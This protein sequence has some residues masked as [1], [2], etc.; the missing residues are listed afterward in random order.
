VQVLSEEKLGIDTPWRL[1]RVGIVS[2]SSLPLLRVQWP[3]SKREALRT[4]EQESDN[5]LGVAAIFWPAA[6]ATV[7]Y[8]GV[9]AASASLTGLSEERR[10]H[11]V[12]TF[13]SA[14][15]LMLVHEGLRRAVAQQ[16]GQRGL[17]NLFL[18]EKPYPPGDRRPFQRMA[19]FIAATLAWLPPGESANEY[20]RRLNANA[21]LELVV[22]QA[23]LAGQRGNNRPL[24]FSFEVEARLVRLEDGKLDGRVRLAYAG[25]RRRFADWMAGEGQSLLE[26]LERAYALTAEQILDWWERSGRHEPP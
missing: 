20:L 1:A 3:Q 12:P 17:T 10:Q 13:E 7:P 23:A 11:A 8:L 2:T 26:E 24:G 9:Q 16:S 21:V 18:V 14:L 19:Y 5:I 4:V 25:P 22:S 15:P 6:F